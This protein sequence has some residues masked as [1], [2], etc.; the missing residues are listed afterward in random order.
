MTANDRPRALDGMIPEKAVGGL[1]LVAIALI[2]IASY[3]IPGFGEYALLSV[4]IVCLVA[5]VA[6]REYGYAVAAGI[7]GGMGVGVLLTTLYRDPYDGVAFMLAFAGGFVAVWLL[8]LFARPRETNGW[9]FIP[10]ILFVAV[11]VTIVTES[12]I[13][14]DSL[15]VI[16]VVALI[17][18]GLKALREARSEA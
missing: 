11:A 7:T 18:F 4:G 2:V 9:P 6:T 5:F 17:A 3:L 14:L 8:G 12:S 1:V 10:A 16:A 13:L 15:V